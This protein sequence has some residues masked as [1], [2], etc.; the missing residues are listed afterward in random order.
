MS[1]HASLGRTEIVYNTKVQCKG[2]FTVI[3]FARISTTSCRKMRMHVLKLHVSCTSACSAFSEASAHALLQKIVSKRI[4]HNTDIS[5]ESWQLWVPQADSWSALYLAT[6]P[7]TRATA[8]NS[9][10]G[11]FRSGTLLSAPQSFLPSGDP[12]PPP[13]AQHSTTSQRNQ[14]AVKV[15][16]AAL[17]LRWAFSPR[18]KVRLPM[19]CI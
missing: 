9:V 15:I 12:H 10:R 19:S 17:I 2:S 16:I 8:L 5:E 13:P 1:S 18:G 7:P 4:S 3:C 11:F 6:L 14:E